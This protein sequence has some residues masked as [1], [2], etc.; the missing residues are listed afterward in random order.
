[1]RILSPAMH[2]EWPNCAPACGVVAFERIHQLE[3]QRA[4]N[5][6]F[7]LVCVHAARRWQAVH[8]AELRARSHPQAVGGNRAA[9]Q[10]V[11]GLSSVGVSFRNE[12]YVPS[13][14]RRYGYTDPASEPSML[15]SLGEPMNS[16]FSPAATDVPKKSVAALS[17]AEI[18]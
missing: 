6:R 5:E 18:H 10:V 12:V 13:P 1:M 16:R 8:H 4:G 2:T 3:L 15:L 7:I 11:R 14:L 9:E 17:L